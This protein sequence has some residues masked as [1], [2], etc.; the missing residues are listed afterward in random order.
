MFGNLRTPSPVFLVEAE[1]EGTWQPVIKVMACRPKDLSD[2]PVSITENLAPYGEGAVES[3]CSKCEQAI[4]IGP[5]QALALGIAPDSY[6]VCCMLC[7]TLIAVLYSDD[8]SVNIDH[9][10]G[11]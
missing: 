3:T 10:G 1:V 2:L 5:R 11:P 4:V 8:G 6:L 7:A 9:L